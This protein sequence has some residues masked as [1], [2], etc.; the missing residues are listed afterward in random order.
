MDEKNLENLKGEMA[1]LGFSEKLTELM[2]QR[3]AANEPRFILYDQLESEKGKAELALHFNQSRSSEFYYFN[4]FDVVMEV[5]PPLAPGEKYFVASQRQGQEPMLKEFQMASLAVR[6]FNASMQG[7]EQTRRSAQL[8]A[9]TE[10]ASSKELASQVDGKIVELDKGFYKA[11]MTPAPGQTIYLE[12]GSGFTLSQALNLLAGRSVYREDMLNIQKNEYA[13][14]VKLEFDVR[15]KGGNF[16]TKTFTEGYGYDLAA[17]LDRF[18]FKE[19][20]NPQWRG[21]LEAS[22][23]NGDRAVVNVELD[24]KVFKLL[25]EAVPEYKQLNLYSLEGKSIKREQHLKA[26]PLAEVSMYKDTSAKK[27]KDQEL[28]V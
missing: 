1:R 6:E 17:V 19:L 27:G 23:K 11:L 12:K 16:H 21:E 5:Q 15:E 25:V 10:L 8:Y 20:A 24:G 4:K 7:G 22:L 14:W 18:D 2:E 3:M 9:G 28:S 26:E 13:A